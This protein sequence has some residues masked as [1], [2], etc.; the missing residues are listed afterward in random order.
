[1]HVQKRV[2]KDAVTKE[3]LKKAQSQNEKISCKPKD[4]NW[5]EIFN[6]R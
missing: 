1:M 3:S 5:E 6:P 2:N 4:G